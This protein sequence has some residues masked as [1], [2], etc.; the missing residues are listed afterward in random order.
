MKLTILILSF[1]LFFNLVSSQNKGLNKVNVDSVF[2]VK[3]EAL[4]YSHKKYMNEIKQ[5]HHDQMDLLNIAKADIIKN[6]NEFWGNEAFWMIT[7]IGGLLALTPLMFWLVEIFKSKTFK[8]IKKLEGDIQKSQLIV[9]EYHAFQF[10]Q[11]FY[12]EDVLKPTIE[13]IT[14]VLIEVSQS[15][16]YDEDKISEIT[17]QFY[18]FE[19]VIDL[20][21]YDNDRRQQAKRYIENRK[22]DFLK[23]KMNSVLEKI[24]SNNEKLEI[25]ELLKK[26]S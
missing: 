8:K 11:E 18:D 7:I 14:D 3:S 2:R 9:S 6:Q 22:S 1:F 19:R 12:F 25:L 24:N 20:I 17:D 15:A 13:K 21:H 10:Y 26:I 4:E 16:K 5:V 23:I